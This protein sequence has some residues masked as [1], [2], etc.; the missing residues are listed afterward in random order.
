MG[1]H[2]YNANNNPQSLEVGK[3]LGLHMSMCVLFLWTLQPSLSRRSNN[4]TP[5][6]INNTNGATLRAVLNRPTER[7]RSKKCKKRPPLSHDGCGTIVKFWLEAMMPFLEVQPAGLGVL[8]LASRLEP[9]SRVVSTL[10]NNAPVGTSK[11]K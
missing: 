5:H 6:L 2:S 3:V 1:I 9:H 11:V 8:G 4:C 7:N 10:Y